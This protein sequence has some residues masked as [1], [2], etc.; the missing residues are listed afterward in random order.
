MNNINSTKSTETL[1]KQTA[2]QK[3]KL[4]LKS[5]LLKHLDTAKRMYNEGSPSSHV[6]VFFLE[7]DIRK[8]DQHNIEPDMKL[9]E[10]WLADN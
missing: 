9:W 5:E 10:N 3:R 7:Q 4:E 2:T 1:L 8:F 6:K